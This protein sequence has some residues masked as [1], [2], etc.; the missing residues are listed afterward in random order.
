V[1]Q[2]LINL[3]PR[4]AEEP[5]S[6]AKPHEEPHV[7]TVSEVTGSIKDM[8]DGHFMDVWVV[9]EVSG[10]RP[11]RHFYFTLKDEECQLNAVMFNGS[12]RLK[13]DLV[14]GLELVCHGRIT[15]YGPRGQYQIVIDEC[16][17]KGK[18][19]LQL[20][21]EQ[22]KKKLAE[23]GLFDSERK[24]PIPYLPKKIGVVTSETGAAVRDIIHVLTRRYPPIEVLLYPVKV[25]GD[26]AA[27]EV[28]AAIEV[29]NR[30]DDIDVLI[31]GRGGG[32]LEDL[33]AFNEE[34]VARAI[35][36]SRI[37]VISAVGHEID[38]T[39]ADFVADVKAPTPS[40][41]AEIAVPVM[42][43]LKQ[44]IK[45]RRR[46][47]V[48][49]LQNKVMHDAK[50]LARLK[51]SI[52]D[53]TKMIP[54]LMMRVDG[55]RERLIYSSG[56]LIERRHKAIEAFLDNLKHLSPLHILEKGYAVVQKEDGG[57]VKDSANL[58][59]DEDV[60]LTFHKG[61]AE[62]KVTKVE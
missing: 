57:V 38:S 28:A 46:Q 23:E 60:K 9:G 7:M 14:D 18:G 48:L 35:F 27:E 30:R 54:D 26:G 53:P 55:F 5:E 24:R 34:V 20:Q 39:I 50:E 17:P 45:D 52:P 37:P 6:D 10:F 4:P 62:A 2:V 41:A 44:A 49:A 1:E 59:K 8:M 3:E 16:F 36:A 61:G 15:V 31:V 51:S 13:F 29:L 32:S 42:D 56:I 47:L 19:A 25:Q 11:R 58:K 33:W 21:F 12:G 43:D 40:A 22:L